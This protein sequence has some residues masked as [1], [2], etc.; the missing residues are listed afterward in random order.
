MTK[1]S[2]K[3]FFI[4]FL[5]YLVSLSV[6]FVVSLFSYHSVFVVAHE[7][8]H[9]GENRFRYALSLQ[10]HTGRFP[11]AEEN[12]AVLSGF[13]PRWIVSHTIILFS[14]Y[15]PAITLTGI[16]LCYSLIFP[17]QAGSRSYHIPFM[18]L[19]GRNIL[20]FLVLTVVYFTLY[21]GVRPSLLRAQKQMSVETDVALTFFHQGIK[22]LKKNDYASAHDAFSSFLVLDRK[23]KMIK[24]VYDWT[25]AR[26]RIRT[27]RVK[28]E[29]S[30]SSVPVKRTLDYYREAKQYF[31]Q[32][33]YFSA[34]YYAF[35]ASETEEADL[36]EKAL[37]LMAETEKKLSTLKAL[38][39]DRQKR[40]YYRRKMDAVNALKS[41]NYYKAYYAFKQ[42]RH[43][44][45]ADRDLSDFF[46]KSKKAVEKNYFFVDEIRKYSG[47]PGMNNI[48]YVQQ[49]KSGNFRIVKVKK[50][51]QSDEGRYF[52]NIEVLEVSPGTGVVEHYTAPYGKLSTDGYIMLRAMERTRE[53]E[54]TPTYLIKPVYRET[55]IPAEKLFPPS[56]ALM[57]L[58]KNLIVQ[59][60]AT[61]V[62]LFEMWKTIGKYGYLRRPLEISLLEAILLPFTFFIFSLFAV[63]A[64]WFF[65][66]RKSKIP[67]FSLIL[68]PLIP[69]VLH[70]LILLY[71]FG[72]KIFY[73]FILF[74]AGLTVSLLVLF[75][76]QAVLLFWALLEM[77]RQEKDLR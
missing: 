14:R 35:L 61:I 39:T 1:I 69:F 54:Y 2:G 50:Y 30:P 64:G 58:Q 29:V 34:Y 60:N 68:I 6:F 18:Q 56:G 22:A 19:V 25:G 28:K 32:K 62:E 33:N 65:R 73:S 9:H 36:K 47:I 74:K 5:V 43:D 57:L 38:N 46:R 3:T 77:A 42:L 23:N 51:I 76:M 24:D 26:M 17:Y 41:G 21:E 49:K 48:V 53:K 8:D 31:I 13:T 16:L 4:V 10:E 15:L 7:I 66:I 67:L 63:T 70:R 52:F 59:E 71:L 72:T 44:F 37:R 27:A 20:L 75:V 12:P 55:A 45:P 40:L 11:G